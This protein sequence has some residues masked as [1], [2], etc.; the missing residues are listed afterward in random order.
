MVLVPLFYGLE[1]TKFWNIV[2]HTCVNINLQPQGFGFSY[3]N[4]YL[5]NI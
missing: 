2:I 1:V 4:I 5:E 3:L